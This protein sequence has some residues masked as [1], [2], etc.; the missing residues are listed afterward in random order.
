MNRQ[1]AAFFVFV[2]LGLVGYGAWHV[3]SGWRTAGWLAAPAEVVA[4]RNL[5]TPSAD[6]SS[7]A[8]PRCEFTVRYEVEGRAYETS[9]YS[10]RS[11]NPAC[12]GE[13]AHDVGDRVRV[14]YDP[15]DPSEAVVVPGVGALPY[16][17]IALGVIALLLTA[18]YV[19]AGGARP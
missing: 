9:R 5:G 2:G 19:R 13:R 10:F 8:S 7:G 11:G 14:H 12:D 6:D 15:A 17:W 18:W 3:V 16:L 1:A 4:A